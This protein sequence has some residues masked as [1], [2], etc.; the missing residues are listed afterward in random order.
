MTAAGRKESLTEHVLGWNKRKVLNMPTYLRMRYAKTAKTLVEKQEE[1]QETL[2]EFGLQAK[3]QTILQWKKAVEDFTRAGDEKEEQYGDIEN[4][5]MLFHQICDATLLKSFLEGGVKQ[6][7]DLLEEVLLERG[8]EKLVLNSISK[9][10]T[11]A[12]IIYFSTQRRTR[13]ISKVAD[14][15]PIRTKASVVDKYIGVQRLK[16]E[17]TLLIREMMNFM[18]YYRD[19]VLNNLEKQHDEIRET[20]ENKLNPDFVEEER[21]TPHSLP[22]IDAKRYSVSTENL[23]SLKGKLAMCNAGKWFAKVANES[24]RKMKWKN[25]YNHA[26]FV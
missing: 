25:S 6:T 14:S 16:K 3:E 23:V 13:D 8:K 21:V 24:S 17:Q 2:S 15:I 5:F 18:G 26:S 19:N 9:L 10:Q 22:E 12:E 20:I 1:L 4:Y 7:R 11:K